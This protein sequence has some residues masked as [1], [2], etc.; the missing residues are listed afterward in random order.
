MK[1]IFQSKFLMGA[2]IIFLISLY[3]IAGAQTNIEAKND[4]LD[5]TTLTLNLQ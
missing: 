1:E 4:N 5:K 3:I 2:T